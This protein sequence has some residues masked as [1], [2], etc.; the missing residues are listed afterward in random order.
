M[1]ILK[2]IGRD[3][4]LFKEDITGHESRLTDI[5]S[6]SRF[7]IIGG[8]GSIGQVITKELF[9]RNPKKLHVIDI[10]ENNLV[11][12]VRDIR[13]SLGYIDGDFQTYPLDS[14][15]V[16]YDAFIETDGEY[17]YVINLAALKHVR[18]EKDPFTTMRMLTLN[19]LNT[20]K[21]LRQSIDKGAIKYFC[22]STDKANAPVNI[23]GASKLIMEMFLI[24]NSNQINISTAR[25][26]NVAFSS[27][28]L[29]DSFNQRIQ[30]RQPLAAPDDVSRYF[31]TPQECAELSLMSCIFG[32]NLDIFFPKHSDI[33]K[34]V[35]FSEI[36]VRYLEE[37][38][39]EPYICR[40]E[41]EARD[42]TDTLP[43][44]GKWPCLFTKS[45]TT[46]EKETEDFH[47]DNQAVNLDRFIN[48]GVIKNETIYDLDK[49]EYFAR[50]ISGMKNNR[51]WTKYEILEL[52]A[53]II[54]D[55]SHVE[56]EKYLYDK[57]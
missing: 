8:A 2:I 29:L 19:I 22:A 51:K 26:A 35:T 27:G 7:L 49:T 56:K 24:K 46:G 47:S 18:N 31:I 14:G 6:S 20:A 15:S 43:E 17:D 10:S 39:Y 16:E 37:I 48:I 36:L 23:Y 4:E 41:E 9:K 21:T 34:P 53:G 28:S 45:D 50:K 55:F 32:E 12:L 25:F 33:F 5:V 44:K 52:I 40:T 57:M 54:P 3:T 1:D 38:G 42:L 13:S 30:K 11:E